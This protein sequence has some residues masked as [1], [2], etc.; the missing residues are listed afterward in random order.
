[1]YIKTEDVIIGTQLAEV[2]GFL[3]EVTEIIESDGSGKLVRLNSDF[4]SSKNLW[5]GEEGMLMHLE[6]GQLWE[7][8]QG[9]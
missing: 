4:S 9:Q 2:D 1:M 7:G 5:K 6:N 3:L 8:I